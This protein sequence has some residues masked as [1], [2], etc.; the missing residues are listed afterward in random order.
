MDIRYLQCKGSDDNTIKPPIYFPDSSTCNCPT[1]GSTQIYTTAKLKVKTDAASNK[2]TSATLTLT[3]GGDPTLT[4]PFPKPYT[5]TL[6]TNCN[7]TV[8]FKLKDTNI[9]IAPDSGGTTATATLKTTASKTGV[10]VTALKSTG[11]TL[12]LNQ[13]LTGGAALTRNDLPIRSNTELKNGENITLTGTISSFTIVA[14]GKITEGSLTLKGG[15][16]VNLEGGLKTT[17]LTLNLN[18]SAT[19]SNVT[20]APVKYIPEEFHDNHTNNCCYYG[21]VWK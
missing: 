20:L 14:T 12:N 17:S 11:V 16:S 19:I 2:L 9:E 15:E 5:H 8:K 3:G 10:S 21:K 4:Y 18:T 6:S 1:E 7:V 13:N